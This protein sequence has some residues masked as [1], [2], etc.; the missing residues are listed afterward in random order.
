MR[1]SRS[2][3][4]GDDNAA[5][6]R[7]ITVLEYRRLI[8]PYE[9]FQ[10]SVASIADAAILVVECFTKPDFGKQFNVIVV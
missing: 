6:Y 3:A 8:K 10:I 5:I 9:A 2:R 1:K 4:Q 7:I